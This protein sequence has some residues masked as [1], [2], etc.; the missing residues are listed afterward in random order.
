MPWQGASQH[1]Q[2]Q[3]GGNMDSHSFGYSQWTSSAEFFRRNICLPRVH[4]H[5]PTVVSEFSNQK[6]ASWHPEPSAASRAV[7]SG[8]GA[9]NRSECT[10]AQ[11]KR[12]SS[13]LT[14]KLK[15]SPAKLNRSYRPIA[16]ISRRHHGEQ[17]RWIKAQHRTHQHPH[18]D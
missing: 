9:V 18:H 15:S 5:G 12:E 10:T 1:Q 14:W 2:L 6:L 13:L 4:S 17:R 3:P 11:M 16:H 8:R 7:L